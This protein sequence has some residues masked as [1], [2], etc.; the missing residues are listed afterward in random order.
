MTERNTKRRWQFSLRTLLVA[1]TGLAVLTAMVANFPSV[2]IAVTV[3]V[4]W[5]LDISL[6]LNWYFSPL[7]D[8]RPLKPCKKT[9]RRELSE[10]S[11]SGRR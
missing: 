2:M 6:F 5:F 1:T 4:L 9:R 10:E 3:V 8:L 11:S 7:E